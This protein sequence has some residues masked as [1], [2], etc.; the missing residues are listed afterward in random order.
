MSA[1]RGRPVRVTMRRWLNDGYV[2]KIASIVASRD[3]TDEETLTNV[4]R[5]LEAL[6]KD[7]LPEGVT[8][9]RLEVLRRLARYATPSRISRTLLSWRLGLE[10]RILRE[11]QHRQDLKDIAEICWA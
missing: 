7:T 1:K 10:D 5:D 3:K 11:I 2:A 4:T 9:H 8:P 6:A